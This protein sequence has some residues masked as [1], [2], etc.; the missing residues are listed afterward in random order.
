[1]TT[2]KPTICLFVYGTLMDPELV[3]ALTG[4]TFATEPAT[5]QGYRKVEVAGHYPYIEASESEL[6]EG[7]LILDVDRNALAVLDDYEDEGSMYLRGPATAMVAGQPRACQ[8][9]VGVPDA[10]LSVERK[11]TD[12]LATSGRAR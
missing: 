6:V 10:V 7:A 9:Y 3:R 8:T 4:R 11:S 1:M 5:L 12:A 2:E